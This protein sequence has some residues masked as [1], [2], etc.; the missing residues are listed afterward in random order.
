MNT[1]IPVTDLKPSDIFEMEYG[2]YGNWVTAR[3]IA[4]NL[5]PNSYFDVEIVFEYVQ[6]DPTPDEPHVAYASSSDTVKIRKK[7]EA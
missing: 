5:R 3:C 6:N 7:K 1:N 4:I 2:D